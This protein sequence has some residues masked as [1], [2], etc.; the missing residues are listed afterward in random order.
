MMDT[1]LKEEIKDLLS[2]LTSVPKSDHGGIAD[3]I[4][5]QLGCEDIQNLVDLTE[6]DLPMLKALPFRKLKRHIQLSGSR[7]MMMFELYVLIL[8]HLLA[9]GRQSSSASHCAQSDKF[10]ARASLV[11][12]PEHTAGKLM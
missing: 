3:Y 2:I 6:G 1:I 7:T 9:V 11:T 12:P 8:F 5:D 4:V 10:S